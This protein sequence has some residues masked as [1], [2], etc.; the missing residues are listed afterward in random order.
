MAVEAQGDNQFAFST[1]ITVPPS[2]TAGAEANRYH[3]DKVFQEIRFA[4][5]SYRRCSRIG[6]VV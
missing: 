2:R 4:R 5:S 6:R 1:Y 3:L